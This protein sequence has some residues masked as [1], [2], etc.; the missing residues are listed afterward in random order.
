M[1][2][3]HKKA[4]RTTA[5]RIRPWRE[6]ERSEGGRP[7]RILQAIIT[8]MR[9][10]EQSSRVGLIFHSP[11]L[12]HW[13]L[14]KRHIPFIIVCFHLNRIT[15][16]AVLRTDCTE[17]RIEAGRPAGERPYCSTRRAGLGQGD[18]KGLDCGCVG[19]RVNRE[20]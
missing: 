16:A 10:F 9:P 1:C 13:L 5:Q 4:C 3:R 11:R 7:W 12:Q 8:E 18:R 6:G 19:S 2:L 15:P 20:C 14:A 17:T